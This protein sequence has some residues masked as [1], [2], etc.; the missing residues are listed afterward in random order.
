MLFLAYRITGKFDDY[1]FG[2]FAI[3]I[4]WPTCDA[5]RRE[6]VGALYS[7]VSGLPYNS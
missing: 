5:R 1:F 7:P 6:K 2:D 4:Y 3:G